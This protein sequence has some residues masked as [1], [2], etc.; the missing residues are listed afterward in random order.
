MRF[1]LITNTKDVRGIPDIKNEKPTQA[2]TGYVYLIELEKG[3]VK[4]GS[5]QRP[6]H[7]YLEIRSQGYMG[8]KMTGRAVFGGPVKKCGFAEEQLHAIFSETKAGRE[9]FKIGFDEARKKF[10]SFRPF[11]LT[12]ERK[13][14]R[15]LA[16][17]KSVAMKAFIA[18]ITSG[19]KEADKI[20]WKI[21]KMAC[22]AFID[23][24]MGENGPKE[25]MQW[26]T[27]TTKR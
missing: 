18:G 20:D 15:T 19:P 7:R 9:L 11:D 17:Y 5:T 25:V 1:I 23:G 2:R 6:H 12:E 14:E 22:N 16:T 26:K 24:L 13:R 10:E 27:K 21:I 4:I 8:L 3:F